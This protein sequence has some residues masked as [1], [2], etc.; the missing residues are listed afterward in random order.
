[1]RM[2]KSERDALIKQYRQGHS[3][4]VEA[5]A[6]ITPAELDA[7]HEGWTAREVVHHLADSE[8]TSAIRL[9]RLLAEDHPIIGGYDEAM[10]ARVLGYA[11]RP[12][13]AALDAFS[14]ARRTTAEILARMTDADWAREGTHSESGRYTAEDWLQIYASHGH[15]HADQIRTARGGS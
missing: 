14:A 13:D 9:R 15:D 5:L 2:D 4:V 8:M 7:R 12:I 1:M 3:V 6:G 10:F 11:E